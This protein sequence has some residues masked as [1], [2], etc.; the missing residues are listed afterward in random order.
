MHIVDSLWNINWN[1]KTKHKNVGTD[2]MKIHRK[3]IEVITFILNV[4][5]YVSFIFKVW[6]CFKTKSDIV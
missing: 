6:R 3:K 4:R 5:K 2:E 1:L